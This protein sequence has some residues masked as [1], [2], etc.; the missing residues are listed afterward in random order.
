MNQKKIHEML[1]DYHVA[2]ARLSAKQG[3]VAGLYKMLM[4]CDADYLAVY[5][6]EYDFAL[7]TYRTESDRCT[8]LWAALKDAGHTVQQHQGANEAKR[9]ANGAIAQRDII[10]HRRKQAKAAKKKKAA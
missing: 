10:A 4:R 6:K 3:A 8:E 5:L 1:A 7:Y 2:E 9:E